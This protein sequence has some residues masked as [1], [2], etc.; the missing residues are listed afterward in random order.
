M[1]PVRNAAQFTSGPYRIPAIELNAHA[2]TSNKTPSGTYRGPGRFEGCFFCD[3][4]LDLAAKDLQL[5]RLEI[6]RRNLISMQEMPYPLPNVL[7]NDG[8]GETACDSGDY[9]APFERS[10]AQA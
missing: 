7:P 3:R 4:M 2:L 5:D 9:A 1:T 6:R 8:F 10:G